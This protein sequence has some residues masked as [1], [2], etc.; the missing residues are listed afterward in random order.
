[1]ESWTRGGFNEAGRVRSWAFGA[2]ER[3]RSGEKSRGWGQWL[4]LE[5]TPGDDRST[6]VETGRVYV[7]SR[8]VMVVGKMTIFVMWCRLLVC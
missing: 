8:W 6:R 2:A 4:G 5:W 7:A 3:K 1:M